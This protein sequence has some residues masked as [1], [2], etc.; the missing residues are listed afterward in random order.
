M[1]FA[2]ITPHRGGERN[3]FFKFC[4]EQLVNISG[5]LNSYLMNERPTSN[6]PDLIPR[7]KKGIDLAKRDGYKAVYIVEDDDYY[8]KDYFQTLDI[9]E[10]DFVGFSSTTYYNLRNRTY[11]TFTHPGRSS[12]FTTAFKISAMDK[13]VWPPDN[14]VF[15]DISLWD[16]A[17]K[18]KKKVKLYEENPCL[19]IKHSVGLCGGKGHRMKMKNYD[20]D[21]KFL[22]SRVSDDAFEFYS[23]IMVML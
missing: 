19:G 9:G 8:P 5:G 21:L 13:F 3:E 23:K 17:K 6:E 1:N 2:T 18:A 7:I 22:R 15:L 20:R 4:M 10:Y 12:L 11:A 16:Y 14:K